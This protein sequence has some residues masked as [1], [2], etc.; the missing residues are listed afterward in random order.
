MN[1][2]LSK[3]HQG[4][5][6]KPENEDSPLKRFI[7]CD[8]CGRY[9]RAYKAYKNQKYYYKCNT[10]GCNCNKRADE[11]HKVVFKLLE[12]YTVEISEDFKTLLVAQIT[13]T[14]NQLNKDKEEQK[15]T[16]EKQLL[17]LDKKLERLE[18]R[19]INEEI[20]QQMFL[21]FKAKFNAEKVEL[22][23]HLA[24]S[25]KQVSNL[26][27]CIENA[28]ALASKLASAWDCSDYSDK[29]KLQFL[30]FPEGITYNRKK[31]ECRTLRINSIIRCI[32]DSASI[33]TNEKSEGNTVDCISS[34]LVEN[35]GVEPVTFPKA[36]GTLQP[37]LWRIPETN[38]LPSLLSL[39]HSN[40]SG[41][42][43]R[44]QP[45]YLPDALT[46]SGEYRSRTGYL[47]HAMQAL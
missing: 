22:S 3:N 31:D 16:L 2:I 26:E 9:L 14:Y 41:P 11:L 40:L 5:S 10:K 42:D 15:A 1:G 27:G 38:R 12:K 35:T 8:E 46:V 28:I 4:Y 34:A 7:K 45:G 21:K 17:E 13:A 30:V 47:L 19:F 36:F 18:E 20:D 43:N 37:F 23:K 32:I 33:S 25:G 24:K 39:G 29:Q 6:V 44:S